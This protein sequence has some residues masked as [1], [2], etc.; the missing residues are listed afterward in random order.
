MGIKTLVVD[1]TE[2]YRDLFAEILQTDGHEVHRAKNLTEARGLLKNHMFHLVVLDIVL[3]HN[4]DGLELLK[5]I[6][7]SNREKDWLRT[8][9]K[10]CRG[11]YCHR[12]REH[13]EE[14]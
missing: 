6:S 1:D 7:K 9:P 12:Y 11:R 2:T 13:Q 8:R 3:E 14:P 10:S 4:E 5:D